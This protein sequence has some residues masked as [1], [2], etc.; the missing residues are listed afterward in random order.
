MSDIKS[1]NYIKDTF[2]DMCEMSVDEKKQ[3]LEEIHELA[4]ESRVDALEGW[5]RVTQPDMT[6]HDILKKLDKQSHV[7]FIHRRG[8]ESWKLD[9][10]RWCLEA[11]FTTL[12]DRYYLFLYANEEHIPKLIEKYGLKPL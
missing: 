3:L 6:F 8:Y 5:H 1:N 10:H 2:Y 7:V 11:G 4:Y 12:L 9:E